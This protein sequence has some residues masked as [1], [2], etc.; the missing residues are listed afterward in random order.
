MKKIFTACFLYTDTQ[1][2]LGMKKRG[3]GAGRW[4]GFGGKVLE[5]EDIF[6]AAQRELK[7]AQEVAAY[8]SM[9]EREL[10]REIKRLEKEMHDYA[11]NLDFEKAAEARD[12]LFRL[13]AGAFG[14]AKHD[15]GVR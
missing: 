2:L 9:S 6:T 7:A 5:G 8:E 15:T 11:K 4:N 1:L 10:A 13:K 12:A 14:A 3:F